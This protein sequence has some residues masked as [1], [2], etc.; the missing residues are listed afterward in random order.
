MT[1]EAAAA[2]VIKHFEGQWFCPKNAYWDVNAYRLG[3]G[4]DTIELSNGT[5][6][7]VL[8]SDCTMEPMALK[9]LT[10]RVKHEFMPT[11][12]GQIG[13]PYWFQLPIGAKAALISIGYNY[14]R[15]T[16]P[17][18]VAAAKTGDIN[19]IADAIL[20]TTLGDNGG[21]NDKRRKAE[22]A[23][24]RASKIIPKSMTP[25]IIIAASI[26]AIGLGVL[27]FYLVKKHSKK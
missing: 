18:I 11:V 21:V 5:H 27:I 25:V 1:V 6:R 12:A 8:Q 23:I 10:R 16:K 4:S 24:V 20:A 2:E 9:D 19:K 14:G 13:E 7:K 17:A 3:Y 26:G 15:I 22:A